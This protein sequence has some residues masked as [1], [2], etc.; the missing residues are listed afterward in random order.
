LTGFSIFDNTPTGAQSSDIRQLYQDNGVNS[1]TVR[2]H[3][4]TSATGARTVYAYVGSDAGLAIYDATQARALGFACLDNAT[5]AGVDCSGVLRGRLDNQQKKIDY[6]D[7]MQIGTRVY[8]AIADGNSSQTLR[9]EIWEIANPAAPQFATL[10]YSGAGLNPNIRGIRGIEFFEQGGVNY[11]AFVENSTVK[12]YNVGACLDGNGCTGLGAPTWSAAVSTFPGEAHHLT[13]SVSNGK[14]YIYF[15]LSADFLFGSKIESLFDLTTL[16]TTNL[17]Q[18]ITAGGGTY[19][20]ECA[21]RTADYW[22]HYY[23]NN[24]CGLQNAVPARGKFRGGFFY[25]AARGIFDVHVREAGVVVDPALTTTTTSAPPFW[26]NDPISFTATAQNCAGPEIWDWNASDTLATGLGPD[27]QNNSI[28]WLLCGGSTCPAKSIQVWALKDAC[29]IAPNLVENRVTITVA[30]PRP[31]IQNINVLP[32][33]VPNTYPVC[34]ELSFT[35]TVTGKPTI[36]YNW[37]VRDSSDNVIAVPNAT[38]NPFLWDTSDITLPMPDEIFSDG[39]ESGD[40]TGWD[41]LA[42]QAGTEIYTVELTATNPADPDLDS[43]QVTLEALEGLAFYT[44]SFAVT[45]LRDGCL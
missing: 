34:T 12:I 31:Q 38:Q 36:N 32:A 18:E 5:T 40:L 22:G 25:R 15:G 44:G 9:L 7:V 30:D 2:M 11:L 29:A 8:V 16:G 23:S 1:R 35:A 39:F 19:V 45:N 6:V 33:A 13:Y 42:P 3:E 17:V 37:E 28:T 41:V 10:K 43:V 26:F 27:D 4:Y 14:P 24:S 20:E 21:S